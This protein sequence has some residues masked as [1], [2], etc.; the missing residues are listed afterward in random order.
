MRAAANIYRRDRALGDATA[1]VRVDAL[2]ITGRPVF[3]RSAPRVP[4]GVR[5]GSMACVSGVGG[6]MS[7]QRMD[8]D[9]GETV[10]GV[11]RL[12]RRAAGHWLRG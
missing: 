8:G 9:T 4:T 1:S 2:G 6:R 11:V 7:L 10:A 5:S 3:H 12:L